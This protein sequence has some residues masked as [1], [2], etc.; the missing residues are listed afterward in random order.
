MSHYFIQIVFYMSHCN[1][2]KLLLLQLIVLV[3]LNVV[4][5][6]WILKQNFQVDLV[7]SNFEGI[8]T[9]YIIQWPYSI[10]LIGSI[11]GVKS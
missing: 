1:L 7:N 8:L 10:V 5:S 9:L 3:K 2:F 4:D 11:P 6:W